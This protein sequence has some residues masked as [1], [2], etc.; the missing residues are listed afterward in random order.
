MRAGLKTTRGGLALLAA[1]LGIALAVGLAYSQPQ[2]AAQQAKTFS[3]TLAGQSMIRSDFRA[4]TPDELAKV[5]PLLKGDVVF[6]NFESTVIEPGQSVRDGRFLTPPEA[7]DA[8]KV[9]G[10][11]LVALA[12]NHAYDLKVSGI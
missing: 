2:Q 5:A 4:H 8:L 3:I 12:D 7:L 10:F 1:G 11:N 6:T 9:L